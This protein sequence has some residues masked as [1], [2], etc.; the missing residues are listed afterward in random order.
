[1]Y[2]TYILLLIFFCFSAAAKAQSSQIKLEYNES[3]NTV[4]G[5][6]GITIS[7]LGGTQYDV[8]EFP[9]FKN[10]K[11]G[12]RNIKHLPQVINGKKETVHLIK[13]V[14]VS[15]EGGRISIPTFDL[16]I[17]NKINRFE[18]RI[19][20]FSKEETIAFPVEIEDVKL[21]LTTNKTTVY[22]GEGLA[23]KL[24]LLISNNTTTNWEFP[25]NISEQIDGIAKKLKPNDCIEN[26]AVISNITSKTEKIDNKSYD[27]YT[28]YESIYYS[29]NDNSFKLPGIA[30]KMVKVKSDK[31][32]DAMLNTNGV[33]INV[34]NLPDHPLKEKVAVGVFTSTETLKSGK[35]KVTG[36]AFEY[37]IQINGNGNLNTLSMLEVSKDPSLDIF[38]S[39]TKLNQN[40]GKAD[41]NKIF[42]YKVIPKQLGA[43]QLRPYFNFVYFNTIS[44]RYD[45]LFAKKAINVSGEKIEF[46]E[47]AEKDIFEGIDS[48]STLETHYDLRTFYKILANIFCVA[49]FGGFIYIL[50]YLKK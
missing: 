29:L 4:G 49:I 13:Q 28:L 18:G 36:E 48:I 12:A 15:E 8:G 19:F 9:D 46:D 39:N 43:I 31:N 21:R 30:L 45:T 1:M 27:V 34:K 24:Q 3:A 20:L 38:L 40:L 44:E 42:T 7:I 2:K 6:I 10:L 5:E 32:T 17:N 41:G 16:E 33:S 22:V 50:F 14:Y 25:D 47:E 26:R 37:Q 23:L 35:N 11:K